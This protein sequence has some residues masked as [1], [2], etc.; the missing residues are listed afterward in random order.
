MLF[1]QRLGVIVCFISVSD[2][3]RFQSFSNSEVSFVNYSG[4]IVEVTRV[5][6]APKLSEIPSLQSAEQLCL[7]LKVQSGILRLAKTYEMFHHLQYSTKYD[8]SQY[9]FLLV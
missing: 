9:T 1:W 4:I 5:I 7:E 6:V 8:L 2:V 3:P